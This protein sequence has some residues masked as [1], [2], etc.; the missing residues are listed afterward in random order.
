MEAASLASMANVATSAA[1]AA[2]ALRAGVRPAGFQLD[3]SPTAELS[4]TV[5]ISDPKGDWTAV[6]AKAVR[7]LSAF[8]EIARLD[9]S[10]VVSLKCI[11]V[12]YYDVR[13]AQ[14]VLLS[15]VGRTEPFPPEMHDCRV[16]LVKMAAFLEK[17]PKMATNGGFSQF[18]ELAH[19]SMSGGEALVEFYDM[20]AAQMLLATAG[21]AASP[22]L[23]SGNNN[24]AQGFSGGVGGCAGMLGSRCPP[25]LSNLSNFGLGGPAAQF[26]AGT[27]AYSAAATVD[28]PS[29]GT[30]VP[31]AAAAALLRGILPSLTGQ[32][33]AARPQQQQPFTPLINASQPAESGDSPNLSTPTNGAEK[34][35]QADRMNN[36]PVRTKVTNK[37]F[38]KYDINPEKIQR[39]EDPR[40]TVMVRNLAGPNARKE[41]LN[42]LAKCELNEKFTFFYM[43]CKEHRNVPAGFAFINFLS[44]N[45]V[46]KLY[47]MV[48]SDFWK[49]FLSE[50]YNKVPAMSYGRFQGHEE[51]VKHFTSS[52]VLHEQDP[53]KRPI[54]RGEA[55]T[56][57]SP[58]SKD[59]GNNNNNQSNNAVMPDTLPKNEVAVV[60]S[61]QM[62]TSSDPS[63][64]SVT[65]TSTELQAALAKGCAEIAA[66]LARQ[67]TTTEATDQVTDLLESNNKVLSSSK[68]ADGAKTQSPV[69]TE[70]FGA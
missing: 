20:R 5:C 57:V 48:K 22:W 21:S 50:T 10:F 35:K 27:T 62:V 40:T 6:Q 44:P 30:P 47:V 17:V 61:P 64:V 23:F 69:G 18:G 41:F 39:G 51:L 53:S 7:D 36:R 12:T 58:M 66:I 8:G 29:V 26:T 37:E 65:G 54:F 1:A 38:Q 2:A 19:I 60:R 32:T 49:E 46:L 34:P 42:F 67:A 25:G 33:P 11:L 13:C 3:G 9:M 31:P 45:D 14:K 56:N 4:T 43:P 24:A 59:T 70:G 28:V 16:V 55:V 15:M 52:A 68:M 63:P